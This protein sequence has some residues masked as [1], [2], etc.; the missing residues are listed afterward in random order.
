MKIKMTLLC[1]V[2]FFSISCKDTAKNQ[3]ATTDNEDKSS[4]ILNDAT[5]ISG[6]N[7]LAFGPDNVLFIGDS[8]ASKLYAVP[9][10]ANELKEPVPF[11]MEGFDIVMAKTLNVA[12]RDIVIGDMKI[13]P[14]SQE[15]YISVKLGHAP[16]A[17]SVIAIVNPVTAYIKLLEIAEDNQQH[18]S[19]NNP[20][21]SDLVFWKETS[22]STLTITDID[23]N[24]GYVYIAGLTNSEFASTLRK[25]AYPFTDSQE[26]VNSIEIYHA[27]HTQNETR[28]PI[29][30]MLFEEMDGESTL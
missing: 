6:A 11:N 23:Y 24:D 1:T 2:I 26:M 9:T 18:I 30:T 13:H 25:I 7:I 17:K 22:A 10:Q 14:K 4:L 29:R 12:P 19:I 5:L 27:V 8:K 28:A 16:E 15:A 21:S 3:V 20:A